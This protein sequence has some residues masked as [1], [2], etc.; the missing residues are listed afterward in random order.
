MTLAEASRDSYRVRL[1]VHGFLIA[2]E[3]HVRPDGD[4]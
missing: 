3:G 2:D 4:L 1:H